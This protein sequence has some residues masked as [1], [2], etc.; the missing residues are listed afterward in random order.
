M[1]ILIAG[2]GIAGPTL[3]YWLQRAGYEPTLVERAPELRRGGYLVD[4]W[5]A[6]FD[7][8][9][10]MGIVPEVIR[11]GYHLREVRQVGDDGHRIA[12]FDP[13]LFVRST[14]GRYVSIARSELGAIIYNALGGRVETIFGDSVRALDDHG[15]RVRVTFDSG[16]TRDF[17]LVIGADGQH[18]QVRRLMFGP[19]ERFEKYLGITVAA[20]EVEGYRPRMELVAVMYTK[21]GYQVTRV[22]L[23]DDTT[24]FL[25][26]FLDD[27]SVTNHDPDAQKAALRARLA[28]AGWEIPAILERM[29]DA[30]TFYC[31]RVSQIRMPS[32]TRG[33]VALLGDAGACVSLLAG[34]GSAL[35]MVEAY[36]LA[37]ELAQAR[38][39]H[40]QAFARYEQ[41]LMP[42]LRSKQKAALRLATAF[43]P[44]SGLQLFVRNSILKLFNLPFVAS[45]AMGNSLRDAI[46]L[47]SPPAPA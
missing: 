16:T 46:E 27:G 10:R 34:Q 15:A 5:G 33:R 35:A 43:A 24:M 45:L 40:V 20:F 14:S 7:V 23:R 6:G 4:F 8:A 30:K 21:V 38:G 42:F 1:N 17:D 32:W 22:S 18:S 26:T 11:R 28:G 25:F 2:A 3:A 12:A 44:R 41:P 36:V 9:D 19:E 39:N 13:E 37:A 47:P 31:D 29:D